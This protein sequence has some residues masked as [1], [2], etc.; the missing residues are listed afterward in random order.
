MK[1]YL[2][3]LIKKEFDHYDVHSNRSVERYTAQFKSAARGQSAN[4]KMRRKLFDVKYR[5]F[6]ENGTHQGKRVTQIKNELWKKYRR[7]SV[8]RSTI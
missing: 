4:L 8:S 7:N 5:K 3:V 1:S 6:I 2:A